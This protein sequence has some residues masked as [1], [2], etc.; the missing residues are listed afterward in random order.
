MPK[1]PKSGNFEKGTA[2]RYWRLDYHD[3]EKD[4]LKDKGCAKN[5]IRLLKVNFL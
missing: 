3:A 4:I 5:I 2:S 1:S